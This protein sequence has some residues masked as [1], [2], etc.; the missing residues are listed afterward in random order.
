MNDILPKEAPYAL[1]ESD[2]D[3]SEYSERLR[4]L[5]MFSYL[6]NY[7]KTKFD[8][9]PNQNSFYVCKSDTLGA[10]AVA[11]TLPRLI[12]S[13]LLQS[14]GYARAGL[15]KYF[16]YHDYDPHVDLFLYTLDKQADLS[17]RVRHGIDGLTR[18]QADILCLQLNAFQSQ[19]ISEVRSIRFKKT[20]RKHKRAALKNYLSVKHY[21]RALFSKHAR[22]LVVRVDL[23][24]PSEY[25]GT[26]LT[27]K[28][29]TAKQTSEDRVAFLQAL[30][31]SDINNDLIGYCWKLEYGLQKGFHSHCFFFFDGAKV[32]QDILF[33]RRIGELW[34]SVIGHSNTYWN[35]NANKHRYSTP[36]IGMISHDDEALRQGLDKA[37]AYLT[38]P[39]Y[40]LS[41][42]TSKVGRTLGKGVMPSPKTRRGRPRRNQV[43]GSS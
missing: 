33:G 31:K 27:G 19:L 12:S 38:K 43:A 39:D 15:K 35:C 2:F 3:Q 21:V 18:T 40:V 29:V 24:Y 28:T 30:K 17:E 4:R 1:L 8:K 6:S 7:Y 36:G 5:R 13:L 32:R 9:P 42:A 22:L 16:P 23:Y 11:S 10:W 25:K 37:I 41:L 26:D 34:A 20:V 14:I